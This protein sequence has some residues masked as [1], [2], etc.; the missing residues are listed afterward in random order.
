MVIEAEQSLRGHGVTM[1]SMFSMLEDEI[2]L[3][4][5][6]KNGR[7]AVCH[8]H[9]SVIQ[10]NMARIVR[11]SLLSPSAYAGSRS[12]TLTRPQKPNHHRA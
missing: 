8:L 1:F 4:T 6:N 7:Y 9:R 5:E 12:E 2:R 10:L 3:P 11:I